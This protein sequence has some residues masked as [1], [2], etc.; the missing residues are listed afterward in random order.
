MYADHGSTAATATVRAQ[1][2]VARGIQSR[3]VPPAGR[4]LVGD[5]FADEIIAC[6]IEGRRPA[7]VE[8]RAVAARIWAEVQIGG[9]RMAW[10]DVVPGCRRHHQMIAAA[11][12]A[13]GDR[14]EARLEEIPP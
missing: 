2:P 3:P 9:P 11:R 12:A 5:V 13:L 10:R 14:K 8:I 1:R 4:S 7:S 6:M